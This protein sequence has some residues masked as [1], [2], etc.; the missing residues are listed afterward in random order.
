[1]LSIY[2]QFIAEDVCWAQADQT[3]PR[4]RADAQLLESNPTLGE[5]FE[6]PK[7][8]G[9]FFFSLDKVLVFFYNNNNN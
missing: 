1:M 4:K 8:Y 3:R 9:K 2:I 5:R 6:K 7:I